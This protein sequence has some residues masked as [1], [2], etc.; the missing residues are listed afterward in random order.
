MPETKELIVTAAAFI[1]ILAGF[2]SVVYS[3]PPREIPTIA[4]PDKL[5]YESKASG[6]LESSDMTDI[7]TGTAGYDKLLISMAQETMYT[8][9]LNSGLS[10]SEESVD[11]YIQMHLR[12]SNLSFAAWNASL[13]AAGLGLED[14]R[15]KIRKTLLANENVKRRVLESINVSEGEIIQF[16]S[17][18]QDK[19]TSSDP[20]AKG[21][22]P[23]LFEVRDV[24]NSTIRNRKMKAG[25]QEYIDAMLEK[26][27]EQSMAKKPDLRGQRTS[28]TQ[29]MTS[30]RMNLS[31]NG[32]NDTFIE[33]QN[34]SADWY[35]DGISDEVPPAPSSVFEAAKGAAG[36][37]KNAAAIA[38]AENLTEYPAFTQD[39]D[40][41]GNASNLIK[42]NT[43]NLTRSYDI[44]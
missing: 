43:S 14:A 44:R 40:E 10:V 2:F 30:D 6:L 19:F 15:H 26:L 11:A 22:L 24:I 38:P 28:R 5:G 36:L 1:F 29:S 7:W 4:S 17:E 9:A 3:Q 18:N 12:D 8:E 31:I 16:F 27:V 37:Q 35:G 25:G 33:A 41:I 23:Q 20:S 39:A 21:R 42:T 13:A 34:A 32:T